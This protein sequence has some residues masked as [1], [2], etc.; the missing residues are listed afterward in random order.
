MKTAVILA[1]GRGTRLGPRG[2]TMPKGF[3]RVGDQPIIKESI[4]RLRRAGVERVVLVTGHLADHYERFAEDDPGVEVVLNPLYA[5]SGSL[6]SLLLAL[7][8]LDVGCLVL[9]SDLIYE[10]AG[11]RT[12]LADTRKDVVLVSGPTGSGDEVWVYA[13]GDHII[14]ISKERRDDTIVGEFVGASKLSQTACRLLVQEAPGLIQ[15]SLMAEYEAEGL[16]RLAS[17]LPLHHHLVP[18]LAWAEID[19]P[20]HLSRARERVYPEILRREALETR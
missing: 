2:E 13:D 19:N 9:E 1:A 10:V 15:A 6:C 3:L 12:L 16:R 5:V 4:A 18:D 14:D 7:P 8:A 17:R 20:Q 11:I